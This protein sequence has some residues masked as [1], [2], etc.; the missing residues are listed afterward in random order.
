MTDRE[1]RGVE[2]RAADALDN[3]VAREV[4]ALVYEMDR[5]RPDPAAILARVFDVESDE[6]GQRRELT[7]TG[8]ELCRRARSMVKE[9]QDGGPA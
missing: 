9:I 3:A 7:R 6:H 8:A 1:Q 2:R 4:R 5:D